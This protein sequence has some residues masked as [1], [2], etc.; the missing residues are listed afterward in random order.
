MKPMPFVRAVVGAA[1]PLAVLLSSPPS[2]AQSTAA[3]PP[4]ASLANEKDPSHRDSI[5]VGV[6]GGVGFPRPLAVEGVVEFD[7]LV[8]FGAEYSALPQMTVSGVQTSLWALAGDVSVFPMRNGFFIGLRAGRQHLG[9]LGSLTVGAS[10][11]TAVQTADTTFVN[12]RIGFLWRFQALAFGIDAG[13]QIPVSTSTS[14]TL[15]AGISPP[16]T[17][18]S[19]TRALSEQA[20]PTVDLLRFGV[21]L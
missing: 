1:V 3:T 12:P 2:F 16:A 4:S 15:P 14:S 8:L 17:A 18:A 5:N 9:E 19:I 20:I 13:V 21:V 7:R 6:L 11:L 10:T